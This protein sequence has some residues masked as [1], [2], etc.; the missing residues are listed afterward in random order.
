M[1]SS[2]STSSDPVPVLVIGAGESGIALGAQLRSKLGLP[3]S[4]IRI[5]ERQAG[6]GGTWHINRYPGV[7]CDVPAIFYS[8]SFAL[9]PKWTSFHPEG[10]EI[11]TYLKKVA[12]D[13]GVTDCIQCDVDVA[14][15]TWDDQERLWHVKLRHLKPGMGDLSDKERKKVI[16]EKGEDAVV[17][18]EEIVKAKVVCSCVGGLVE[19]RGWPEDIKGIENFEGK[20][21]HSARWDYSVDLK[22]K[23]VVVVGTG[24]SAAQFVP[25]LTKEY[26]AKSVTQIMR[27]PPWVVPRMT[28]PGG[29][30]GWST[31]A[32]WLFSRVPGLNRLMRALV[33]LGSEQDWVLFGSEENAEKARAKVCQSQ[34]RYLY[35]MLNRHNTARRRSSATHEAH[36]PREVS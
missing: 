11:V 22:D 20:M 34:T 10:K 27:S 33:F 30:E 17:L 13:F 31:W 23:N 36:S 9:N 24:C 28:P 35:C 1:T 32:P 29:E 18:S 2:K 6:I 26:G 7:A 8:F 4:A 3:A 12:D 15:C 19:P 5:Y 14:G 25:R 16:A 21:F